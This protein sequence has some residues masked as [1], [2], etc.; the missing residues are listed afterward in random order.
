MIDIIL[1]TVK[2]IVWNLIAD[3]QVPY[4]TSYIYNFPKDIWRVILWVIDFKY[5]AA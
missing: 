2:I 5:M 3:L 1:S 4:Q